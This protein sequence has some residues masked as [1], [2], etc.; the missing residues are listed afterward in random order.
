MGKF[1]SQLKIKNHSRRAN[2]V[3]AFVY[4]HSRRESM[5]KI[6]A[7]ASVFALMATFAAFTPQ[8]ATAAPPHSSS[9]LVI[10]V[11]GSGT[12]GTLNGTFTLT[13]FALQNGQLVANGILA[14]TVTNG[15]GAANSLLQ[16]VTAAVTS[17]ATSSCTILHLVLGPINL[18]ILGLQV[19]T[20]Q[21]VL[22]ISAIPGPGNLLGNLLCDIANLLNNPN[23][24]LIGLLN[25]LVTVLRGL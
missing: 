14:G 20:N 24:T 18:N 11:T 6:A 22:D 12:A 3:M 1:I 16:T 15:A 17:T 2:A 8:L 10:P 9:P 7:M 25:N 23:A 19:T 21:I 13:G 5:K 4:K